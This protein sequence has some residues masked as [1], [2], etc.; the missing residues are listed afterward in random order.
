MGIRLFQDFSVRFKCKNGCVE[1]FCSGLN[2]GCV[3]VV[4][5]SYKNFFD[6]FDYII[7]NQIFNGINYLLVLVVD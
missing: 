7:V 1:M 5:M 3:V 6:F 2:Y 4:I